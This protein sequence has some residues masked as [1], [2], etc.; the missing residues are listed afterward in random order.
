LVAED[1]SVVIVV[2]TV[3]P[4]VFGL[5]PPVLFVGELPSLLVIILP[6]YERLEFEVIVCECPGSVTVDV[7]V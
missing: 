1:P 6:S 4:V 7:A 5:V 2:E 3:I